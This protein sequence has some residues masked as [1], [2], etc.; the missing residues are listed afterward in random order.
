M[1]ALIEHWIDAM[2]QGEYERAWALE[3]RLASQRRPEGRDDPAQPY[4]RRWIWDGRSFDGCD[5]LVRCYHGLGDTI[6]FLRF[7]P[8]LRRRAASIT[9]EIQSR[10]LPLVAGDRLADR[11]VPFD[12]AR[13]LPPGQRNVEIMELCHALRASPRLHAPPYLTA[14]PAPLPPDVIGLCTTAGDWDAERSIPA[15]LLA[16]LCRDRECITLDPHPSGLP[17][18]NPEGCP[19]D[20]VHTAALIAGARLIVTVDTMVAHLA[21][22]LNKP[23]LLLLKH[24]PDWRWTPETGRSAWYPSMRLYAQPQPGDWAAVVERV[25]HDLPTSFAER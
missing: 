5:V 1:T 20:I 4:H 17:V 12:Q 25:R 8:E 11:L 23:T 7:L 16:P 22:A 9:L 24:R 15:E 18:R 13:P 10:L 19:F 3:D 2:R 6:Q 14:E 21:G